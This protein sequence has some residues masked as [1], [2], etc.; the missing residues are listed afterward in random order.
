MAIYRVVAQFTGG[1]QSA[2]SWNEVMYR[3]ENSLS[4]AAT[5]GV[6][7]F[8]A[9]ADLLHPLFTLTQVRISD[10]ANPRVSTIDTL[11]MVGTYS[12]GITNI[13]SAT[14]NTGMAEPKTAAIVNLASSVVP[15][16]RKIWLRGLPQNAYS[17]NPSSGAVVLESLWASRLQ[18]WISA[19]AAQR[20]CI[21][22]RHKASETGYKPLNIVSVDGT[23]AHGTSVVTLSAQPDFVKD[24]QVLINQTS[25]KDLPGLNSTW[26]ILAAPVGNTVKIAYETPL[27]A[28]ITVQKGTMRKLE[29]IPAAYINASISG[30]KTIGE[31]NSR[32]PFSNSRG[33]RRS[34]LKGLRT[35][36]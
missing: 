32:A 8:G 13:N 25:A 9:R 30:F 5:F 1:G 18:T 7:M 29:Y 14:V 6:G 31:R 12:R 10:V 17:Y 23:G 4:D 26:T 20:M 28:L 15:A 22:V 24:G 3:T 33:A 2:I 21:L 34:P 16:K 35:S 19:V 36:P 27:N 11:N